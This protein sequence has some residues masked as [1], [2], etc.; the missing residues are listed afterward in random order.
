M[1]QYT[2]TEEETEVKKKKKTWRSTGERHTA[3]MDAL[4]L[5]IKQQMKNWPER[6]HMSVHKNV[7]YAGEF[8][9]HMMDKLR[10]GQVLV[11]NDTVA[12][13][14]KKLEVTEDVEGM[15]AFLDL[16]SP[17]AGSHVTVP[18][19]AKFRGC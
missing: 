14:L 10:A 16:K 1:D 11:I 2:K 13:A 4:I 5:S 15:Y 12:M 17:Q 9:Y 6:F 18:A 7:N 3:F 8:A 19:Q